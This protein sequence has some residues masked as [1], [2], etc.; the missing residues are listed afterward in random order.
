M[1]G[2]EQ[3]VMQGVVAGLVSLLVSVLWLLLL[4]ISDFHLLVISGGLLGTLYVMEQSTGT[5]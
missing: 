5:A 1:E 2:R 4:V 3:S